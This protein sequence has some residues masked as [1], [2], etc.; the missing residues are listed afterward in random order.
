MEDTLKNWSK[1]E[2][3][4]KDQPLSLKEDF[5]KYIAKNFGAMQHVKSRL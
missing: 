3:N 5:A 2:P 4:H 1:N